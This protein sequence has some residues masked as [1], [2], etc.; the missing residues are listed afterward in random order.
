MTQVDREFYEILKK[1]Q[2]RK[3]E[4]ERRERT[5]RRT[6]AR[7]IDHSRSMVLQLN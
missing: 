4:K 5:V 6:L 2:R 1:K 7:P 3:I